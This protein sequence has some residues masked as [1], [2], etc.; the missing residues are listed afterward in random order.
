MIRRSTI[1]AVLLALGV[2]AGCGEESVVPKPFSEFSPKGPYEPKDTELE[3]MQL[4]QDGRLITARRKVDELLETEPYSIYGHYVLGQVLRESEGQLPKSMK[5]LGRARELFETRYPKFPLPEG[6]MKELH[7]EILFAGQGVAGELEEFE[8]QLSMLDFYDS[9]YSPE[10]VAEHAWPLMK[11]GRTAEARKV[12]KEAIES[13]T[14]GSRS[15]GLNAMCAIEGEAATRQPRFEACLAAFDDASERAAKDEPG[16]PP[17]ERTPL[18]VHAYN[19]SQA[20]HGVLRP[21]EVER[22]AIAGTSRLDFTPANPWRVLTRLYVSQARFSDG[23]YALQEMLRWRRRQPPYLREQ[24]RAQTD[25][26]QATFLLAIGRTEPGMLLVDRALERPDRRGL[27]SGT[28]EQATG[29]HALLRLALRRA[30]AEHQAERDSW[31]EAEDEADAKNKPEEDPVAVGP[32]RRSAA[33]LADRERI[34]TILTDEARMMA[35]FRPYVSG[36]LEPVPTWLVGDLIDVVGPGIARVMV[37]QARD[38]ETESETKDLLAPYYDALEAEIALAEGE[39][40]EALRLVEKALSTLPETEVLLKAR[41]AAVGAEAADEKGD[42]SRAQDYLAQVMTLDPGTIRRRGLALP[43][44]IRN[45]AGGTIA[46]VVTERLEDSPR[47]SEGGGFTLALAGADRALRLC[48]SGPDGAELS[49]TEV[50]YTDATVTKKADDGEGDSEE[51][52][53][54]DDQAILATLQAFHDRAFGFGL[55]LS[56]IDLR[57]LDGQT[58]VAEEA[59]RD[60]MQSVIDEV[61]QI[62]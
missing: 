19:A 14:P 6:D 20:A 13:D 58:V 50:D 53:M 54:T 39:E 46:S 61:S 59:T 37:E 30:D 44:T 49:C 55:E 32:V 27:T 28:K 45:S 48:L 35:S 24:D 36:G 5:H 33:N 26:A 42:G 62:D 2:S 57:S 34:R 10:L 31:G 22:L 47:L 29:A 23:I 52:P 25:V 17:D 16:A 38:A 9:L 1:G 60:K 51:V 8:Y 41:V 15:L 12:A 7:R 18:A 21:D 4:Y 43:V 3:V 40:G 56:S 11:L